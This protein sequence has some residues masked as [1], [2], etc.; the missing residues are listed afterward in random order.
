MGI[1][2][3]INESLQETRYPQRGPTRNDTFDQTFLGIKNPKTLGR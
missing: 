2:T 3:E 1:V